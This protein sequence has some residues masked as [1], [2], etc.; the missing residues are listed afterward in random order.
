MG[1]PRKG[2]DPVA[3]NRLKEEG[4]SMDEIAQAL[5]VSRTT[6]FNR[7]GSPKKGAGNGNH[8]PLITKEL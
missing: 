8:R 3:F 2:V 5:G 1:R 7:N 6:L 4:L